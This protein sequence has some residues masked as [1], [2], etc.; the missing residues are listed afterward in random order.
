MFSGIFRRGRRELATSSVLILLRLSMGWLFI[1]SGVNHL[2]TEIDTGEMSTTG[3]LLFATKG[4]FQ[5]FFSS[6]A[7]NS[8][9]NGL[10]V[11][12]L[13]LIGLALILGVFVRFSSVMGSVM[14]V[15]FYLSAFPPEHNPFMDDHIVEVLVFAALAIFGAGRILGL[16]YLLEKTEIVQRWPKLRILLG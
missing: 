2:L 10:V 8:I 9:V 13:I 7:G 5:E 3:Y 14:L 11:W 1:Y 12:G 15:L 4:P 16:D 6:L